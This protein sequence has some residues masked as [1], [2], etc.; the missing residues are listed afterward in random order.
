MTE[1][2]AKADDMVVTAKN[3]TKKKRRIIKS[4]E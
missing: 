2:N 4:R 1:I 3:K